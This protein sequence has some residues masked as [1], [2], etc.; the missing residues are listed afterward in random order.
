MVGCWVGSPE[1]PTRGSATRAPVEAAL[2]PGGAGGESTEAPTGGSAACAPT[3]AAPRGPNRGREST[4]APKGGSA[5]RAPMGA[6]PGGIGGQRESSE[7]PTGGSVARAPTGAAPAGQD[8]DQGSTMAPK[9]GMVARAPMVA[10]PEETGGRESVGAPTGGPIA[11]APMGATPT[12]TER[13]TVAGAGTVAPTR[14]TAA[15]APMEAT[16]PS[17][18]RNTVAPTGGTAVRAPTAAASRVSKDGG[19]RA[20]GGKGP[21][22]GVTPSPVPPNPGEALTGAATGGG[23][24]ATARSQTAP[25]TPRGESGA[26]LLGTPGKANSGCRGAPPAREELG[27]PARGGRAETQGAGTADGGTP[28]LADGGSTPARGGMDASRQAVLAPASAPTGGPHSRHIPSQEE[29][30]W[31]MGRAG[32]QLTTGH[33]GA[34]DDDAAAMGDEGPSPDLSRRPATQPAEAG[35]APAP[36]EEPAAGPGGRAGAQAPTFHTRPKAERASLEAAR[37][38][39]PQVVEPGADRT[40]T[41]QTRSDARLL[42]VL[43][44][45]PH[46][47]T[48]DHLDGAVA[49][50]AADQILWRRVVQLPLRPY[51]VPKGTVGRRF[52]AKVAELLRDVRLRRCNSE[53]LIVFVAVVLQTSHGVRAAKDIRRV[54]DTRMDLWQQGKAAAMVESLERA[55]AANIARR[56]AM[57][58]EDT[59]AR[60]FNARVL[61]GELRTAV[62]V[63][64]SRDGGGVL[65]PDDQCTKTG[66]P[67]LSVLRE[68]HPAMRDPPLADADLA[69]FEFYSSTPTPLP[70]DITADVVERV[71]AKLHGAAGPGGTNAVALGNWLLRFGQES[72]R[73]REE[74]AQFTRWLSNESPSWAAYRALMAGRLVALDKQPGVRP[75]GIGE[76]WRRLFAKCVL[77][78]CGREAT[79]AAGQFNLCV[80]LSGGVEGAFHAAQKAYDEGT[81]VPDSAPAAVEGDTAP[82]D[83]TQEAPQA[84]T[85]RGTPNRGDVD[86]ATEQEDPVLALLV[87]AR[88]GF[89]ELSRKAMLWTVA[90]RWPSG[91]RFAFNCYRHHSRLVLRRQGKACFIV[92]SREGVT[93]GDPLAMVLYGI[94]LSPLAERLKEA[95]P[96]AVQPWFADDAAMVGRASRIRRATTLLQQW[97]PDRGYYPEPAKSIVVCPAAQQDRAAAQL[98]GFQFTYKTGARYLGGFLGDQSAR[99]EWLEP[100]LQSWA[101]AVTSLSSVARRYPQTAYAGLAHSLQSEW[102]YL[103][104]VTSNAGES[105]DGV[106]RAIKEEFVPSLFD[107]PKDEAA[108]MRPLLALSVKNAGLGIRD[109]TQAA[110][111]CHAT[112][113]AGTAPLADALISGGSLDLPAY[114]RD[115][116]KARTSAR[117]QRMEEE[118]RTLVELSAPL[119]ALAKR[120]VLRARETGIWLT[121]MPNRLNGTELSAD[122][123]RDSLRL[124]YGLAPTGLP[125]KCDGCGER[126]TTAH[127]LSCKKGGLVLLRHNELAAEWHHLCAQALTPSAVSDEPVIPTSRDGGEGEGE[128]T[129]EATVPLATRGDVAV[130]GFWRRGT[131]AIFDVRVTDTD[132]PTYRGQDPSKVLEKHEREKKEKYLQ[133]CLAS[134]K[135]FT[136]LVFSVDG[137]MGVEARAASKRVASRLAAKWRRAYSEICG[138]VRS[139]LALALVRSTS[140]CLRGPRDDP[141]ATGPRF[142][143][144]SGH[145]VSLC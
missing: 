95:V 120:R 40:G 98:A 4:E 119:P 50:D 41:S 78:Q 124:R 83:A 127:A 3:G 42:A 17:S 22:H 93:Q 63:L 97:G 107:V 112:S 130:R 84:H 143:W 109:P 35:T 73:L 15:P 87:D 71:A 129:Q 133:S 14:G 55:T 139:R 80:G 60:A 68:K 113:G 62:R 6:A 34:A 48:G 67:V 106:E 134:R 1:A 11:R 39:A 8:G 105:F 23:A 89:N 20:A 12:S 5:A 88:N 85:P 31:P 33:P 25:P 74:V 125:P 32:T 110:R 108:E 52:I 116:A 10:A 54:I 128:G 16:P 66:R 79:A 61:N 136:P 118:E 24:R 29:E 49:S 2:Q 102:M 36:S 70:L 96:D 137:L 132:A 27:N 56:P 121:T 77:H 141:A 30:R 82:I 75:V 59:E 99:G 114:L 46:D 43:G 64:T 140:L 104:R 47:N 53:Q 144:D 57:P 145:G 72:E 28:E 103:Q 94:A 126:F 58:T 38:R 91:A 37:P 135:Q 101:K 92:P 86:L 117:S 76:A 45:Y 122:E 51:H 21:D 18:G 26:R 44:D 81:R 111:H 123:F 100:K 7:A 65:A 90:H 13:G 69:C 138:F 9:G 142:T 19:K 115:S 131:T